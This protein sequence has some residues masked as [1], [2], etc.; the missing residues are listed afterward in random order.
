MKLL[1]MLSMLF[2]ISCASRNKPMTWQDKKRNCHSYYMNSFGLN[3]EK[4]I[5]I[6]K[7]ELERS[8][9]E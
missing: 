6:C 9:D 8:D 7:E 5:K 1:I 2:T 3:T 4:A